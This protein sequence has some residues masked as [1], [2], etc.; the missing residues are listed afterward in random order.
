MRFLLPVE[1]GALGGGSHSPLKSP[2]ES[3]APACAIAVA[4]GDGQGMRFLLPVE[5]GVALQLL[6]IPDPDPGSKRYRR[7]PHR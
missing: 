6:V 2:L 7:Q 4:M 5:V 1:V 3:S